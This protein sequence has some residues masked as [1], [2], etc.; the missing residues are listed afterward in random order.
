MQPEMNKRELIEIYKKMCLI[1]NFENTL[2]ELY[3]SGRLV[4]DLHLYVGEE[5]VAVGVCA[6]LRK[7]DYIVSTHRGH[8]HCI[9]KGADVNRM[10]AELFGKSTG[11]CKGK[12]GSMHLADVSIGMLGASGIV[13]GGLPLAVG[14]GLSAKY[15]GTDQISVCFFG[16]GAS[17]QGTFHE[18]INLASVWD[19]PVIFVC[20]NNQ[21]GEATPLS[22]VMRI[23]NI[24]D[25]ASSYGI[26]GFVID[27]MDVIAVNE[28]AKQAVNRARQGKGPTLME[29]KTYRFEG[30]CVTDPWE[31]Y[32]S[33]E[34]VEEWKKKCP[35][36]H[37]RKILVSRGAF[38]ENELEEIEQEAKRQIEEAVKFAEES[39]DPDPKSALYDVFVS[40]PC[41]RMER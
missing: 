17:N 26:P 20:E 39:P 37:F 3:M 32:R 8:G 18:S 21:Y 10:M 24:A 11:L 12:G 29:C 35:I 14:A 40:P 34:E 1:R 25:R 38:S 15:R 33:R 22:K 7:D 30:H 36:A 28:S 6:S 13:G 9:A 5:A 2:N 31:R 4:G 16:D 41:Q 19:L 23:K 27:G